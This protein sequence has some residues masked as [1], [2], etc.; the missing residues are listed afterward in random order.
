MLAF[1]PRFEAVPNASGSALVWHLRAAAAPTPPATDFEHDFESPVAALPVELPGVAQLGVKGWFDAGAD[2]YLLAA[3]AGEV[4]SLRVASQWTY[5]NEKYWK[6]N[7]KMHLVY[8][9]PKLAAHHRV[10]ELGVGVGAFAFEILSRFPAL[11]LYAGVDLSA[12]AIGVCRTVFAHLPP[13]ATVFGVADIVCMPFPAA[14]FDHVLGPGVLAY[15]PTLDL[16]RQAVAEAVRVLVPGGSAVFSA[17]PFKQ[18]GTRSMRVVIPPRLWRV[19]GAELNFTRRV[20]RMEQ[21]PGQRGRYFVF[22]TKGAAK[23]QPQ[24]QAEPEPLPAA[25]GAAACPLQSL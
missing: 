19:W 14:H 22:I 23:E 10:L 15:L 21:L 25:E 17:L 20:E 1:D 16:V 24:P 18:S 3:A 7:I 13:A 8:L 9:Q 11:Q 5:F 4:P 6:A 2:A 12:A